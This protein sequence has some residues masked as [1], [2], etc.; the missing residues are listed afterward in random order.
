MGKHQI[1]VTR[2]D[3]TEHNL[4]ANFNGP[5]DKSTRLRI[6]DKFLFIELDDGEEVLINTDVIDTICVTPLTPGGGK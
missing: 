5:I 1:S 2:T 4:F 6:I 3:G